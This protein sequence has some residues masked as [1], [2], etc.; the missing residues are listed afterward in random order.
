M[1][2][3]TIIGVDLE[4]QD[5]NLRSGRADSH[6]GLCG[7]DLSHICVD[8]DAN[9]QSMIM[10]SM[11]YGVEMGWMPLSPDGIAMCHTCDVE[12]TSEREGIHGRS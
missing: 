1:G 11:I 10:K 2:E 7:M 5:P 4:A 9:H 8:W 3:V 6:E 12:S